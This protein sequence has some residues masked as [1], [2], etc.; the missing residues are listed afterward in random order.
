MNW[1][2][3]YRL[4]Y[5]LYDH[6]QGKHNLACYQ[7][8]E[9]LPSVKGYA[10]ASASTFSIVSW[11]PPPHRWFCRGHRVFQKKKER[12][13]H[14]ATGTQGEVTPLL[15]VHVFVRRREPKWPYLR[16]ENRDAAS[17]F[18]IFLHSVGHLGGDARWALWE[19]GGSAGGNS[20]GGGEEEKRGSVRNTGDVQVTAHNRKDV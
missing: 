15:C 20:R 1:N 13:K 18:L 8:H 2:G 3:D 5:S 16:M 4:V 14:R 7:W 9:H 6:F 12:G 10:A 11:L 19:T 17:F